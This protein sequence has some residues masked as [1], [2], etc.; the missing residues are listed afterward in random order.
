MTVLRRIAWG[1]ALL[2]GVPLALVAL[3]LVGRGAVGMTHRWEHGAR[4]DDRVLRDHAPV[5]YYVS[6]DGDDQA[7]GTS[8]DAPLRTLAAASGLALGPGDRVLLEGGATHDGPLRLDADDVGTPARPILVGSYGRG[9][10]VID[11]GAGPAVQVIDTG[12]VEVVGLV[13]VGDGADANRGD[14][15][16]FENRLLGATRLA[17]VRVEDVEASGFGG[18]G[19]R[20]ETSSSHLVWVV[21]DFLL[22]PKSGYSDVRIE[23]VAAHDNGLAGI[24]V[25][26]EFNPLWGGTYAHRDVYVG[27]CRA[28]RNV[29]RSGPKL[30]HTGSGIVVSDVDGAV[31]EHSVAYENGLRSE[32]R[33][34]GPVGIWAWDATRV[35]IQHN[36]AYRNRTGGPKDGGGFDLDGGVTHSVMQYNLSY[37]NDGSGYLLAQF[38]GAHPFH[39]NVVRYNVSIGDGRKNST[40]GIL[41]WSGDPESP[42]TRTLVTNNTIIQTPSQQGAPSA[43]FIRET[44]SEDFVARDNVFATSGAVPLVTHRPG[45]R[46]LD[47]AGNVWAADTLIAV[48]DGR[49]ATLTDWRSASGLGDLDVLE[50]AALGLAG[51]IGADSVGAYRPL[52]GSP[53]VDAASGADAERDIVGTP[54]PQ[55]AAPD[56][57]AVERPARAAR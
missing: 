53:L 28:Y 41:V 44:S 31:V 57:G 11:G 50:L 47:L 30:P 17:H 10:A 38:P 26:G 49:A 55:G 46:G 6:P 1:L 23:R 54:V 7:A 43:L 36:V 56:V 5:T 16:L 15:V 3:L 2:L 13:L 14:G 27:H 48:W 18:Y 32:S 39:D 25:Y 24:Y 37:D 35:A 42:V 19:V 45:Q 9:R 51:P 22:P 8:P 33:V 4:A 40:A 34:G 52:P 12:G 21:M 29:G 20:V